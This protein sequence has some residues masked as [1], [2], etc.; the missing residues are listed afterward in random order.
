MYILYFIVMSIVLVSCASAPQVVD[1]NTPIEIPINDSLEA[2]PYSTPLPEDVVYYPAVILEQQSLA[3]F[4]GQWQG[5]WGG[6]VAEMMGY[7]LEATFLVEAITDKSAQALYSWGLNQ[8]I[9]VIKPGYGIVN[10]RVINPTTIQWITPTGKYTFEVNISD[11]T[12]MKGI[13]SKGDK[14]YTVEMKK[15]RIPKSAIKTQSSP[16]LIV[17]Q[18][19]SIAIQSDKTELI[20]NAPISITNLTPRTSYSVSFATKDIHNAQWFYSNTIHSDSTGSITVDQPLSL[21]HSMTHTGH[22]RIDEH[23]EYSPKNVFT[24][25]ISDS[26]HTLQSKEFSLV[27]LNSFTQKNVSDSTITATLY[28]PQLATPS[29][30]LYIVASEYSQL[31]QWYATLLVNQGFTVL[32]HE[33]YSDSISEIPLETITQALTILKA[34]SSIDSSAISALA[35]GKGTEALLYFE[36]QTNT[37]S[38]VAVLSPS[39]TIWMGVGLNKEFRKTA[40]FSY[41]NTPLSYIPNNV[42]EDL[43]KMMYTSPKSSL[44]WYSFNYANAMAV[45]QARIPIEKS[46]TPLF[47]ATGTKDPIWNTTQMVN[48]MTELIQK[49]QP[50]RS[51]RVMNIEGAGHLVQLPYLP[52]VSTLRNPLDETA[53]TIA[54]DRVSEGGYAISVW[55]GLLE[56]Y[57][58]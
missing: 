48:G 35:I 16:L 53:Y 2:A 39:S 11:P 47:I 15:Y 1:V 30:A 50:E 57:K 32:V 8:K 49:D 52:A 22:H 58:E 41:H 55:N 25:S 4:I 29:P 28:S 3:L 37:F 14:E 33:L 31:T 46:T 36:S 44:N 18:E 17:K 56:F 20:H 42:L 43:E 5:S 23:F 27:A 26:V 38:K 24:L 34:Q 21:V 9:G 51:I 19:S 6:D 40:S 7:N 12:T 54:Q 10:P 45:A 13:F